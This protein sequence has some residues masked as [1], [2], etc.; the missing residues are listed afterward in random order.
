MTHCSFCDKENGE[1][2]VCGPAPGGKVV[3]TICI[4]CIRLSADAIGILDMDSFQKQ[5][6]RTINKNTLFHQLGNFGL[7]ISGEAGEVADICKKVVYHGHDLPIDKLVKE[8]GDVLWYCAALASTL[9]MDLSEIAQKNIDKLYER[10]PEGF[11]EEAS[12]N[13]NP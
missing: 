3:V 10:Y 11:S 12:R 5:S 7:G 4:D 2:S 13:R 6:A 8:I 9:G 1:G